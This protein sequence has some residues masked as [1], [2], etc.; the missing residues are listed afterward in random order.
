MW[1]YVMQIAN[2]Q[3]VYSGSDLREALDANLRGTHLV[4]DTTLGNAQRRAALEVGLIRRGK[5]DP[6][7][8][9]S[10]SNDEG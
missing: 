6:N 8:N 10:P 2:F 1:Y 3:T 9:P 7:V 4:E 5:M